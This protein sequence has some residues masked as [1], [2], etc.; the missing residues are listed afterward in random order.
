M[1]DT[2]V[3]PASGGTVFLPA[4]SRRTAMKTLG[5]GG[6]A[7]AAGGISLPFAPTPLVAGIR[8]V[9]AATSD[10]PGVGDKVVWSA[11][12]VN[13]GSRCPLRMHVQDG[14]IRWVETDNTGL[15]EYGAHQVRACARGRSMRR[16]VYHADRLKYP[17]KRVGKRGEGKFERITW[18]E[19]FTQIAASLQKTIADY[20]NEAVYI[21]YGTGTLGGTMTRSWPNNLTAISRLMNCIGG[22][23]DHY[24]T[25]STAQI[26]M[27]LAMTYGGW[28]AG[29]SISDIANTRLV[30]MFGNNPAETTMSGGGVIYHLTEARKRSNARMIVIDPRYTDTAIG[31]GAADEWIPIRPGTDT[32]LCAALAYVLIT[33]NMVDQAFLDSHCVG[34]DE[35]TLPA[36]APSNGHYKAYILGSG[37]DGM[38]K[39]PEWASRITGIPAARIVKLAREIG[40]TKPCY[41]VQGWGPQ[42]HANGEIQARA[43]AMLPILTGNV[44]ISGGNTGAREGG[45][46]I[47]FVRFPVFENPIKKQIS[48]F[49]WTDAIIRHEEMTDKTAGIQNGDRLN[50]PIKFIWNFAGNALTNQHGN[51]NRTHEILQ[52][53]S[54]CEMIVVIDNHMTPSAK[55]ADLLLPDY[56][57]S[58]QMDFVMDGNMGN[59][60]YAI[61]ADQ[62]IEPMFECKGIY[63]MMAGV[64]AKLGP[65]VEQK[66][67]EGR[68][69]EEWLRHIYEL[70]REKDPA[71]PD[72]ETFRAQGIIKRHDPNGHTIAYKAFR[73]DPLAN[74]LKTPS[75]KIEIYSETLATY[76][77]TWT[78]AEDELIHPLPVY[79]STFDGWDSPDRKEFPL[80]LCGFHF[81]ARTHSTY[82]NV[83][84][85]KAAARQQVWIN[86]L[87]AE[88]RG[89]KDGDRVRIF[90]RYGESRILAKVTPRIMPG[91]AALSEG[92]WLEQDTNGVDHAGSVN[93]LTTHRP[94]PLAKGNPQHTNRAQIEKVKEG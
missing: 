34:Y 63:D 33:E 30:V 8:Q 19:A 24:G 6:L 94:S 53:E 83:E 80:Q 62:A 12:T 21:N 22:W 18:D 65:E 13:C 68:T 84:V 2:P 3:T 64:A 75:G 91:V 7:M 11:C 32:A 59:M 14:V 26:R 93:V 71:L 69:Q 52:D 73:D 81:K 87:D 37:P 4:V 45:Y 58:E 40:Q 41:I 74:P 55:Y 28:A 23:L 15:D 48:V 29:N 70:S 17:M 72:F 61:F 25:Y 51:I 1:N 66:F 92:A 56:T 79:A 86:P 82:G 67:T 31:A 46:A 78:L 50:V 9:H 16:R 38:P 43:I 57:L 39:T 85:L 42:R 10:V 47:P 88:P 77:Q 44:G 76:A 36:S 27:G 90:N 54:K 5:M 89:I 60:A 20:G 49:T 35:K